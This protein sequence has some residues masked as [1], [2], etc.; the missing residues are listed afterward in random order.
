MLR[1]ERFM[2]KFNQV[3]DGTESAG[4]G[5]PAQKDSQG[6]SWEDNTQ[7]GQGAQAAQAPESQ[8]QEE[9]P[10]GSD[11]VDLS[12]LPESVQEYIKDLRSENAERRTKARTIEDRMTQLEKG[13][14]S[15]LGIEDENEMS[16]ED[17]VNVLSHQSDNLAFQNAVLMVAVENG[18]NKDQAEYLQ[19]LIGQ[20]GES[21]GEN[22]EISDEL[23]DELLGK[24]KLVGG[25]TAMATSSV[26]G[27]RKDPEQTAGV[28]VEQFANMNLVQK[29]KLRQ[30]SPDLYNKLFAEAAKKRML[31]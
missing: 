21:L 22:E 28:T 29:T 27:D 4:A 23:F 12:E 3:A 16:L 6:R 20:Q 9:S 19:F 24:A 26:D 5:A 31:K 7:A 17:Q 8:K 10:K 25:N 14:K 11:K 2:L 18:L 1:N 30:D 15:A 13:L